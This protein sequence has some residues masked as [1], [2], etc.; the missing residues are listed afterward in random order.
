[1]KTFFLKFAILLCANTVLQ[2]AE[3]IDCAVT[4]TRVS[5]LQT[6]DGGTALGVEYDFGSY[7]D[8]TLEKIQRLVGSLPAAEADKIPEALIL[9]KFEQEKA[10]NLKAI[11]ALFVQQDATRVREMFADMDKI[12]ASAALVKTITYQMKAQFGPVMRIQYL[13]FKTEGR[14]F[15]W[16]FFLKNTPAGYRFVMPDSNASLLGMIATSYSTKTPPKT[17]AP[18]ASHTVFEFKYSVPDGKT[19]DPQH[20]ITL[21]AK[22]KAPVDAATATFLQQLTAAYKSGRAAD[23]VPLWDAESQE[24]VKNNI[25]DQVS[26]DLTTFF[27][28][29]GT[30]KPLLEINGAQVLYVVVKSESAGKDAPLKTF[31]LAKTAGGLRMSAHSGATLTADRLMEYPPFVARLV[32]SIEK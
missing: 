10:G 11:E 24:R 1:M 32:Q 9:K 20:P 30:L 6:E 12:K 27:K 16:N 19:T 25:E 8:T 23:I 5:I 4:Q 31:R 21:F 29:A 18:D 7:T 22:V 2:A 17:F 26:E 28:E 15:A 14:S 3:T 13:P